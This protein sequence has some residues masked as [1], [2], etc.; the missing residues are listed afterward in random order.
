MSYA[1]FTCLLNCR[2]STWGG[3]G[4]VFHLKCVFK[5]TLSSFVFFCTITHVMLEGGKTAWKEPSQTAF[6]MDFIFNRRQFWCN[7]LL[8]FYF[9]SADL[10]GGI[11]GLFSAKGEVAFLCFQ[12]DPRP[13]TGKGL[14]SSAFALL[15]NV[16]G[17]CWFSGCHS[18]LRIFFFF[19]FRI[20]P[21]HVSMWDFCLCIRTRLWL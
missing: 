6:L 16:N 14:F 2:V 5:L 9:S 10:Q 11:S 1:L 17:S 21:R 3:G 20:F 7:S 8:H 19:P 4:I 12:N 18:V 15:V 13:L